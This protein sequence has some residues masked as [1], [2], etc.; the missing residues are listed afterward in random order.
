MTRS[1][2]FRP[3]ASARRAIASRLRAQGLRVTAQRVAILQVMARSTGHPTVDEIYRG[4]RRLFPMIL[5]NTVY[6]TLSALRERGELIALG[7]GEDGAI[8][9]ESNPTPHHHAVC[10]GCR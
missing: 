9:F 7:G 6:K 1:T 8:R 2:G 5:L 3:P 10:L 4:V